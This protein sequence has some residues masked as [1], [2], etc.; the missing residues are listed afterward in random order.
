MVKTQP[1]K[2]FN[3]RQAMPDL[4]KVAAI[5]AVVF[6]HSYTLFPFLPSAVDF[7]QGQ[8]D[9]YANVLRFCVPV[10]IFLW[11]YFL[12]KSILKSGK[13]TLLK[14]FYKILI[15]FFCWTLVYT[16]IKADIKQMSLPYIFV[17][18]WT[19]YG[20]SGQYYF[21]ILFQFIATFP[22]WRWI[23]G[24]FEKY[25]AAIYL[26]SLLFFTLIAYSGLS[27]IKLIMRISD[28]VFIYWWPYAIL[29]IIHARKNIFAFTIPAWLK[30]T[31]IGLI[32]LEIYLLHPST[33]SPYA[34]PAVFISAMLLLSLLRDQVSYTALPDV[35]A[36]PVNILANFTLGIFC[37]NPLVILVINHYFSIRAIQ[38]SGASVIFPLLSTFIV[39]GICV[40]LIFLLKKL[41]LGTLVST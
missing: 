29:G 35:I 25:I 18:Y 10:F 39:F 16:I 8:I 27:D 9:L 4:L 19:G 14:R 41:K 12:E 15:P 40:L 26:F 6:I 3:H 36:G 5:F 7:S 2:S 23:S 37:L 21:V 11:A 13:A 20:W 34:L 17:K 33:V 22:L 32:P 30:I 38:F 31:S 24:K 28:R 1:E